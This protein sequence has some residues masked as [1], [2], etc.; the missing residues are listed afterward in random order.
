MYNI[1]STSIKSIPSIKEERSKILS[2]MGIETIEDI[3]KYFPKNYDDR[4]N[5][6]KI[7]ECVDNEKYCVKAKVLSKSFRSVRKNLNMV[8]VVAYDETGKLNIT[9]FNQKYMY[10]TIEEGEEYIFFGKVQREY[11]KTSMT[12]PVTEKEERYTGCIVP[13]Y[14]LKSGISQL[15]FT[16]AV[17]TALNYIDFNEE[18]T[19]PTYI[20]REH[21]LCDMLFAY[22]N[23][24]FPTDEYSLK[25]AKRR[26]VFEE[27]LIFEL[28]LLGKKGKTINN[29]GI[30]LTNLKIVEELADILP[31]ELTNAQKRVIR[32][33]AKDM[34]D[35]KQLNRLVQG[36]VG[37]GKT[38][39]AAA[40]ILMALNCGYQG[41]IMAPTE[42]LAH[43]HYD[44]MNEYFKHFGYTTALLTGTTKK[45]EKEI[46]LKKL[47]SGEI[48]VLIGTQDRKSVV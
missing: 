23:I 43:Q 7:I 5:I 9:Y 6:A 41:A 28:G 26:L 24:H 31:Y 29:E 13:K 38:I 33:I 27:L 12:N 15:V 20:R 14:K 2:K 10:S 34:R 4:R 46:I 17:K 11:R 42:I 18:E 39:V 44:E 45:K 36:D 21:E 3:I 35:G 47:K 40:T 16:N 48:N 32:E 1:S 37:S 22:K 8:N 25:L 30:K 19:L